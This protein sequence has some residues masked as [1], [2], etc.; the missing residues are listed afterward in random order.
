[1]SLRE[2]PIDYDGFV[3]VDDIGIGGTALLCLTNSTDC[4]GN[5]DPGGA[6][7]NW[8]FP[9]GLVVPSSGTG[10]YRDRGQSVV[11]LHRQ[12][13]S[14]ERGRFRCELLMDT[15]YVNISE[16]LNSQVISN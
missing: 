5:N 9:D 1:M 13:N 4:C 14:P 10:F 12:I 16:W 8:F 3:D 7:G 11:R 15:I 6:Q 2:T